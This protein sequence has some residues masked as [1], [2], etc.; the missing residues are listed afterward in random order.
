MNIQ[1]IDIQL[2]KP[3]PW[4]PRLTM[5]MPAISDLAEDIKANGLL[6][7]PTARSVNSHYEL[8][9]GHR[10]FE[11]WKL[12]NP[13]EP[14]PVNV[15]DLSDRQMAMQAAAENGQRAD[16]NQIERAKNIERLID[17]F[18]LTQI[19]AGK[20][21]GLKSQGAV[22]NLVR[23][24]DLPKQIQQMLIDGKLAERHARS[25]LAV[26]EYNLEEAVEIA[27]D[28][29][30]EGDDS[31]MREIHLRQQIDSFFDKHGKKLNQVPWN[32]E[33]PE[34]KI[35]LN[36]E[37]IKHYKMGSVRIIKRCPQCQFSR[38]GSYQLIY[39][40]NAAC[41]AAK[42]DYWQTDEL[43]RVSKLL[44][45]KVAEKNETATVIYGATNNQLCEY[46]ATQLLAQ[47]P[48]H[49]RL[50]KYPAGS[51]M[52]WERKMVLKSSYVALAT[53]NGKL[54][55]EIQKK[56]EQP[57]V[58]KTA[59]SAH[60]S[61][62]DNYQQQVKRQHE[63]AQHAKRMLEKAAPI[64]ADGMQLDM[65][66]IDLFYGVMDQGSF[67]YDDNNSWP[68]ANLK[69]KRVIVTRAIIENELNLYTPDTMQAAIEAF[70]KR[71]KVKPPTRDFWKSLAETTA[72][73]PE[74][75]APPAKKK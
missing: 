11:A 50:V 74:P 60:A 44:G 18:D 20:L 53:V 48:D 30:Q 49:L 24:L 37:E 42:H 7:P 27:E 70:A 51:G 67:S 35:V 28:L 12:A 68:K 1:T 56:A 33:Y 47:K 26:S 63:L 41:Y 34:L 9:F 40:M 58:H 31:E 45:I 16:L 69:Q 43:K 3:N 39:C 62:V 54:V 61:E 6:Q 25:L 14:F 73:Q 22:S 75:V 66:Y 19:S 10:R 55:A 64:L 2:I 38:C 71:L 15:V 57:K 36:D 29:I 59:A 32:N 46:D 8:A 5:D 72:A 17:E 4:Q 65:I 23:L 13:G 21:Y 52:H